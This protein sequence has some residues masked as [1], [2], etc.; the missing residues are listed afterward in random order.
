MQKFIAIVFCSTFIIAGIAV[1]GFGFRKMYRAAIS[2]K[3]PTVTGSIESSE[4]GRH[5]NGSHGT[6]YSADIDYEFRL[7]GI[8]YR[9]NAV[10]FVG[11]STS[12]LSAAQET[13]HKY[14]K[15]KEVAVFYDPADPYTSVL[16][17]GIHPS[18]WFLLIFGFVFAS[19]GTVFM[20]I[21]VKSAPRIAT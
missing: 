7:N 5:T 4:L 19:F 12:N 21:I 11:G 15:S 9:N 17:P 6:T 10:D 3:W 18:N 1:A 13:I 14:P 16:E 8:T 20:I 2:A